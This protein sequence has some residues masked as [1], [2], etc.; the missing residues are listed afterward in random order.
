[1]N[2][3][4]LIVLFILLVV[5]PAGSWLYLDRQKPQRDV[6]T[7]SD[8][9]YDWYEK[10]IDS[11]EKFFWKEAADAFENAVK[12]D[13]TFAT[14]WVE[15]AMARRN[16]D[17][18]EGADKAIA[19]AYALRDNVSEMERLYI[20]YHYAIMTK[21]YEKSDLVLKEMAEKYPDDI[22]S[23]LVRARQAW[24]VGDSD[25]A[26]QLYE[27]ALKIDPTRVMCHNQLGYLYLQK[28]DYAAAIA[29][30]RRYA[31][32]A[33]NQPNPHDS[34]GEAYEAAG[35]YDEAIGEY[36]K[37]LEIRPSF[38]H[39]AVHL[40]SALAITGQIERARYTLGQAEDA[41]EKQGINTRYL[42]VH[43]LRVEEVGYNF[44]KVV[45]MSNEILANLDKS[46]PSYYSML[47]NVDV[48]RSFA[49][50]NLKRLDEAEAAMKD[51]EAA[52]KALMDSSPGDIK[53]R[54]EEVGEII[55]GLLHTALEQARGRA[56]EDEASSLAKRLDASKLPPHELASWRFG[57]ARI[58]YKA[59][60][61]DKCLAQVAALEADIPDYPF[62]N[63]VGAQASDKLGHSEKALSYLSRYM[64]VMRHADADHPG[65]KRAKELYAKLTAG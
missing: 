19:R 34:L 50:V 37:A 10:G 51:T 9:A 52:W 39:S 53:G 31:Y 42:V 8:L 23:V 11:R 43:K 47:L 5:L 4:R 1:M 13:S 12:A 29:N 33:E 15:L 7:K 55:G 25:N 14:A 49:L 6:T 46:S 59:G 30:L 26:I 16:I 17:D 3:R 27:N 41:M 61:Y 44:E 58:Y 62:M 35:H 28:G 54:Q 21:D 36:L 56:F 18:S 57:L 40:S 22:R 60:D 64:Q 48:F 32:Y 63:L 38:Y 45:K 24:A 20:T 65:M 2:R